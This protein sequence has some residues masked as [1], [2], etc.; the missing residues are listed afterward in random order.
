[1]RTPRPLAR[2]WKRL[3]IGAGSTS[4]RVTFS[5]STSALKLLYA[6]AI[7]ESNT[8]STIL[9]PF[10]GMN[11][12]VFTASVADLPRMVSTTKRHFCGEIRAYLNIA[13][14]CMALL[15]RRDFF[16]AGMRFERAG[17]GELAQLV[18]DHVLRYQHRHV[19]TAVMHGDG[20]TDHIGNDHGTTR[21]RLD[22]TA[23]VFLT[24]RLHFFSQVQIHER[25]F[26]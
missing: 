16:V 24:G 10:F 1:M 2:A 23:I 25:A 17:R 19:Q 13:L 3:S 8:L 9:A 15:R 14:V 20:Q 4:I 18:A 5:S 22:G 21:P 12:K 11:F 7:A 26:L 6:L